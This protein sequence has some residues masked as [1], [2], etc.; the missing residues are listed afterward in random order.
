M[1]NF[2]THIC[3]R[4]VSVGSGADWPVCM[5]YPDIGNVPVLCPHI[6]SG[7]CRGARRFW[8]D[9]CWWSIVHSGLRRIS[10][11]RRCHC[12]ECLFRVLKNLSTVLRTVTPSHLWFGRAVLS[13]R[14]RLS[15]YFCFCYFIHARCCITCYSKICCT[16]FFFIIWCCIS[17]A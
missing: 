11:Q 16:G 14:L 9:S 8:R 3:F 7:S 4:L 6:R 15:Q 13:E 1:C 10:A 5:W 2:F 12:G 17:P